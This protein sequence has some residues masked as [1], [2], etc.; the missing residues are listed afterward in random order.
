MKL[1]AEIESEKVTLD[2]ERD[3]DSVVAD[4]DGR[5]YELS[6]REP[7]AGVYLLI[8]EGHVYECRV[9]RDAAQPVLLHVH[10]VSHAYDITMTDPKRLRAGQRAG[11]QA[12]R[13]AQVVAPMPGK[14]VRVL[15]EQGAAVEAGQGVVVVEA[16]K[17]Q[18]ELKSPRAGLVV[19]LRAS[20]GATVNAGEL[21]AVIE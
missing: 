7:E 12:D 3:G 18:N 21:L 14:V 8:A 15:V 13:A 6:V 11:A 1:T 5:R 20:V 9:E 2:F 17:M 19:E 10:T 16:M 4:V